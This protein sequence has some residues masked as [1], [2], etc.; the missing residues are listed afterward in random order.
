MRNVSDKSM[1]ILLIG[2][3]ELRIVY[4]VL[5][6][7]SGFFS[8]N[9]KVNRESFDALTIPH[10]MIKKD[11]SRGARHGKSEAQREYHQALFEGCEIYRNSQTF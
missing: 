1:S 3:K 10:F 2:R 9:A 11:G 6:Y 5:R 4:C 8:S 7:L